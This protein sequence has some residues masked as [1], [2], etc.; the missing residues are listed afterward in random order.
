M[1]SV[2]IQPIIIC[3]GSG[4][5]LW[6]LSRTTY[7]KQFLDLTED[8]SL[9]Q[10]SA[11]RLYSDF[12]SHG[13]CQK[14]VVVCNADHRFLVQEQLEG[15]SVAPAHIILEPEG[16]NTAPAL[17]LAT[18]SLD[19]DVEDPVCIVSPADQVVTD[20]AAFHAAMR[21]AIAYAS[22]GSIT[23]LG[24]KPTH[25]ATGYGYIKY[26]DG[27]VE[28][29]VEN[30]VEKPDEKTAQ[31]YVDD[32]HYYWNSGIFIV[33]A[34]IWH[35]ALKQ[36]RPDMYEA[37]KAVWKKHKVTRPFIQLPQKNFAAVPSESI[38][39]AVMEHC[40]KDFDVR[41]VPLDCGWNDLGTWDAVWQNGDK[42]EDGN[43]L[44]GDI[45]SKACQNTQIHASH[46]L[47]GAIGLNDVEIIETPDAVLVAD[48]KHGQ[49]IKELVNDLSRDVRSEHIHP[50]K[51]YR[52][53][54]WFDNIE[55]G[56]HFK[57]KRIMVKP[58]ASLSLQRHKHR[59]EHWVVVS[60]S[61][62]VTCGDSHFLLHKN[63]STYIP[64]GEIHRLKNPG[65]KPL[66][67]IEIQS[68]DYLEEDDI[69][70]LDDHYGR[71]DA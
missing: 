7:P 58:G 42:D 43:L 12:G 60:G 66:E 54:G 21:K 26:R 8:K 10:L 63:Q 28:D 62:E 57:V 56:P 59:A 6:P 41:M 19:E 13:M 25:P 31:R 2:N 52:P 20:V 30:F 11:K 44:V 17:T 32:R 71:V 39:Y 24:I 33:R 18:L 14:P 65:T 50:R 37:T 55:E 15:I 53:W 47:V 70:R 9:F 40:V 45:I 38:D 49:Q 27:K 4:T 51:V 67:I 61:A 23:M 69:E 46:R 1:Q 5:R 35:Q 29:R 36:Y 3:G 68:G 64:Q 16:R 22:A 48:R 34:S